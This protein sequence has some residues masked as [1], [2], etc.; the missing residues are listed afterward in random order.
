MSLS[1]QIVHDPTGSWSVHGPGSR[2]ITRL[3]S[4]AASLDYA[5]REC[6][7]APVT[8][9]FLIDGFYAVVHQQH[10][11]LRALVVPEFDG[12]APAA[13]EIGDRRHS[14]FCRWYDWATGR[15]RG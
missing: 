12:S 13:E 14:P 10:G 5:R 11:W 2:S 1:L 7:A 6:A 15:Q 8:I 9:E 4:L 3:P